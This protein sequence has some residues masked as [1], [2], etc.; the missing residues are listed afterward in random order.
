ML[1]TQTSQFLCQFLH[2]PLS[3]VMGSQKEMAGSKALE[4][5]LETAELPPQKLHKL[6]YPTVHEGVHVTITSSTSTLFYL[7]PFFACLK[8]ETWHF[9]SEHH[10]IWLWATWSPLGHS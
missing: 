2:L 8:D 4:P 10:F 6:T 5:L 1:R 3:L 9:M 7:L